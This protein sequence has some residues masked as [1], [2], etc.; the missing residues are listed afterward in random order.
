MSSLDASSS[1]FTDIEKTY[2]SF[3]ISRSSRSSAR[4]NNS[5][6]Q[7]APPT[8]ASQ[9]LSIPFSRAYVCNNSLGLTDVI[10][11]SSEARRG[12]SS[13]FRGAPSG[14]CGGVWL[15]IS[16]V[17]IKNNTVWHL[18]FSFFQQNKSVTRGA[19][20]ARAIVAPAKPRDSGQHPRLLGTRGIIHFS[21]HFS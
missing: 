5:L 1:S 21:Q 15:H 14:R 4:R 13:P 9:T 12:L 20:F 19:T 7:Y 2:P 17:V 18:Q 10:F 8:N 6:G 11:S 3:G 16:R